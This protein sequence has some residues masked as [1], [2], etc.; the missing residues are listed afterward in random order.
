[1]QWPVDCSSSISVNRKTSRTC[2]GHTLLESLSALA[3]LLILVVLLLIRPGPGIGSSKGTPLRN[4]TIFFTN[5][6][7][8]L[9]PGGNWQLLREG[10]DVPTNIATLCLPILKE[11]GTNRGE[12][13]EIYRTRHLVDLA[14]ATKAVKEAI[15]R[16]SEIVASSFEIRDFRA[17]DGP[18]G[19][20]MSY[21]YRVQQ[22]ANERR[23]R[24][25]CYVFIN[26]RGKG[27]FINHVAYADT[28]PN[29]GDS[30]VKSLRLRNPSDV[31]PV[32]E[33]QP[34]SGSKQ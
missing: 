31:A 21:L 23:I 8:E 5:A 34:V 15:Q 2:G 29:L 9:S 27:V 13:I 26:K 1:M 14:Q 6:G 20:K 10:S 30:T 12:V 16:E 17:T 28:D 32:I 11:A 24:V 4:A 25:E 7:V 18:E 19:R 33:R 22:G 3:V